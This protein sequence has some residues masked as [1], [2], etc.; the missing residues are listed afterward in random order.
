MSGLWADRGD[1]RKAHYGDGRQ[2][3]DVIIELGWEP[4]WLAGNIIKYL[5]RTKEPEHSLESARIYYRRL[6]L[7]SDRSYRRWRLFETREERVLRQLLAELN[8]IERWKLET[9]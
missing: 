5:R 1:G 7:L 8:D 4:E 2:P 9:P 6:V 3:W